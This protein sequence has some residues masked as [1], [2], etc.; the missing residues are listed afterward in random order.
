[1]FD[2]LN[3]FVIWNLIPVNLQIEINWNGCMNYEQR[4]AVRKDGWFY[5]CCRH[6]SWDWKW[7][8]D[9]VPERTA[10]RHWLSQTWRDET[11]KNQH[12]KWRECH[13]LGH[14]GQ[15]HWI[16]RCPRHASI[17]CLNQNSLNFP[18]IM[19]LVYSILFSLVIPKKS[20]FLLFLNFWIVQS[21]SWSSF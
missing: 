17:I 5:F 3:C 9:G 18:A 14:L 4:H 15:S 12:D 19:R 2:G 21:Y 16:F 13:G 20:Y 10:V 7:K 6:I 1:M 11:L 8:T